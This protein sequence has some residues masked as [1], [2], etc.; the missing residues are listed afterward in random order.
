MNTTTKTKTSSITNTKL[1]VAVAFLMGAMAAAAGFTTFKGESATASDSKTY[2]RELK[3]LDVSSNDNNSAVANKTPNAICRGNGYKGAIFARVAEQLYYYSSSDKSCTGFKFSDA[4][5]TYLG[6]DGKVGSSDMSCNT[7][8]G[9]TAE[10]TLDAKSY[11][12]IHEI[13][14]YK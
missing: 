10:D 2:I 9:I 5:S 1:L 7:I 8:G 13:L 11:Y 6:P 4:Y 14:C 3:Y 12:K